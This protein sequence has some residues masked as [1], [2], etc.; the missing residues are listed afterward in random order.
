MTGR[1]P[2]RVAVVG[3]DDAL[4]L[5]VNALWRAFGHAGVEVTAV[6]L[7]SLLRAED[8]LPTLRAQE[9][10]HILLGLEEAPLMRRSAATFSLG[11][12]FANWSKAKPPF[13]C[14]Y[15]TY[16]VPFNRVPFV[17]YWVKARRAGLKA[18]FEDFALNAAAAKQG[19]FFVPGPDTDGFGVSDYAYHLDAGGYCQ[20]LKELAMHRGIPVVS[21]RYGSAIREADDGRLVAVRLGDGREVKADLFV[22]ASGAESVLLGREMGVGFESWRKWFPCDR[23]LTAQAE[24]LSPLP[25]YGQCAAFRSGWLGFYPLRHRTA[26]QQVY[27]SVDMNESEAFEAAGLVSSMRL[28]AEAT[29]APLHVGRRAEIWVKNCVGIGEAAAMLDP[30]DNARMQFNLIGLS[31]L[32]SLFPVEGDF[33]IEAREYNRNVTNAVERIRDYQLAHY[34]LNQRF[35]Q[36][37]WDHLRGMVVPETLQYKIDLFAAR[38]GLA[39]YDDET[40]EEDAWLALFIGHGL[41]PAIYDPLADQ[42]PEQDVMRHFQKILGFIKTSVTPMQ[43][44]EAFLDMPAV[45]RAQAEP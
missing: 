7:P 10:F 36:P 31:H 15:G 26:F 42:V 5:G 32:I 22:D 44:M 45:S 43:P 12:R 16:G 1:V 30:I 35:D 34:K 28:N 18:E 4:W 23:L 17:H 6:E 39:L 11:Q 3:R 2:F 37:L 19:R 13:L 29:V 24:P 33:S 25:P 8:V 38:G 41:M 9:A 40:F 14:A 20:A 21:G 27:A